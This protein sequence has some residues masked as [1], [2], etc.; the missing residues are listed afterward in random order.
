M[1]IP[2]TWKKQSYIGY[3]GGQSQCTDLISALAVSQE[4]K[5]W[6][7][8]FAGSGTLTINRDTSFLEKSIMIEK[9]YPVFLMHKMLKETSTYEEYITRICNLNVDKN[10][11]CEADQA[12]KNNY[13]GYGDMDIAVC[14]YVLRTN[15]Y[16][17]IVG[18]YVNRDIDYNERYTCLMEIHD[19]YKDCELINGD[20]LPYIK[21]YAQ[22]REAFLVLDPPFMQETRKSTGQYDFEYSDQQHMD[23]LEILKE[24]NADVVLMGYDKAV[25]GEGMNLY[26][27]VLKESNGRQWYKFY[28]EKKDMISKIEKGGERNNKYQAMW[29]NFYP[30]NTV[31]NNFRELDSLVQL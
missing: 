17:G 11:Y 14:E 4:S 23:L 19:R 12:K 5:T 10:L 30:H 24:A 9:S 26:D 22:Y 25:K 7:D 27:R 18:S 20:S 13:E 15:A 1:D 21:K 28:F 31:L 16:S 2:T 29:I 3:Y 8:G 6:L